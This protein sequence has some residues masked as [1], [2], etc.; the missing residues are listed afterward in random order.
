MRL[1]ISLALS[2]TYGLAYAGS[3]DT[4]KCMPAKPM[5]EE[6]MQVARSEQGVE[7]FVLTGGD[8]KAYLDVINDQEPRTDYE[9]DSIFGLVRNVQGYAVFGFLR[10]KDETICLGVRVG[11]GLHQKAMTA[12]VVNK[13]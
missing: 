13:S 12:A 1:W 5:L 7:P 6:A 3:N 9:A 2:M 8:A 4:L 10:D 11:L